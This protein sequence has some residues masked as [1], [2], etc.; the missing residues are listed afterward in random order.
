MGEVLPLFEDSQPSF[1]ARCDKRPPVRQ[2]NKTVRTREHLTPDEVE[3]MLAAVRKTGG[4]LVDRDLLLIM[5]AYRHG[6]R[7]HELVAFRSGQI[8]RKEGK[9]HIA[10]A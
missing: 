7:A 1:S 6:L 9:I 3:R 5:M 8:D 2:A 10:R 4:R